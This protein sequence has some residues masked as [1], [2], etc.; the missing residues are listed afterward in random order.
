MYDKCKD[1]FLVFV[2]QYAV[3]QFFTFVKKDEGQWFGSFFGWWDDIEITPNFTN[4]YCFETTCSC[5]F[6]DLKASAIYVL[7]YNNLLS[8][9]EKD[10]K[11]ILMAGGVAGTS[12]LSISDKYLSDPALILYCKFC[13]S[14][15]YHFNLHSI[16]K[17]FVT[18]DWHDQQHVSYALSFYGFKMIL[19]RPNNFG[20]VPIVLDMFN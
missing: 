8:E 20:R 17:Y 16:A 3:P 2:T 5:Y 19:D 6:R 15:F 18:T 10:I 12:F 1:F 14:S 11:S 7:L 9:K 4:I 13:P